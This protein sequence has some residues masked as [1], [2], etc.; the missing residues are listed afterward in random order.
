[1]A[2]ISDI[3]EEEASPQQQQQQA[4]AGAGDVDLDVL[5]AVLERKGG[6]LP[7][8][9]AA[10]DVAAARSDLFRDPSAVGK[11]TAMASAARAKVEAEERKVRDAKRKAEEAERAAAAKER[12]AKAAVEKVE[13]PVVTEEPGAGSSGEKG[14]KMEVEQEGSKARSEYPA[15]VVPLIDIAALF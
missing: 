6:A 9:H 14:D 8:L 11:V 13:S 12:A 2:I 10:I 7:F 5:A 4:G 1:M 3:Q 15:A